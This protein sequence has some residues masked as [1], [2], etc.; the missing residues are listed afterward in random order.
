M[1]RS[2]ERRLGEG[3]VIAATEGKRGVASTYTHEQTLTE[4][5]T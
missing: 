2:L 4:L 1:G 5:H 3:E